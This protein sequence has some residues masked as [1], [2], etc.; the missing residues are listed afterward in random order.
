LQKDEASL[1]WQE[2]LAEDPDYYMNTKQG[3]EE[4]ARMIR[5]E[6]E[7]LLEDLGRSVKRTK[8]IIWL[9]RY[10]MSCKFFSAEG[11]KTTCRR[12]NVRIVKPFYGR[13]IWDSIPVKGSERQKE[14]IV[15]DIDWNKKWKE[16]SNQIVEWA[17]DKVNGGFPYF[18]YTR[19]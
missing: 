11:Q 7:R 18:C 15:A 8:E 14:R 13:P 2:A 16:I 19:D 12:W 4:L 1:T 3:Q 17:I 6:S 5:Q 9:S 10:C